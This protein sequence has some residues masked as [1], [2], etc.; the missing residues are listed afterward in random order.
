M[1]RPLRLA[2]TLATVLLLVLSS[3]APVAAAAD[4]YTKTPVSGSLGRY[5]ISA[6]HVAGVSS[7]G[8]LATQLQVAYSARIRGAAVFAAG[9]YYCAQNN[10]AQALYGCG[11]NRYPTNL[12]SLTSY[13]RTWASYGWVDGVGNLGGQPV[14]V[15][16]GGN[17]NTVKRS[18]TDDLVR[19]YQHFGASVQYDSG[20]A[21]GHAWVTPYGTVG[22]TATAAPFLN[23][24]GTDP[25]GAFLRK[26]LGSVAAPNT[27]P[28]GGTL[29]R[30]G[31]NTYAVNGWANG[32]SMDSSGFVYVPASCAAGQSCR[33][34]VALHGCLQGYGRVGT[35]FVD[36][37]NLNQYADTNRL[38]VLYP[39]ATTS[40]ANPNGCWDWWGY[41]GATNYPIKGGAQIETIMNMVR[42]LD[43]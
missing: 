7:G 43:G 12:P 33:L 1:R 15:F 4:P 14:Y 17:D 10:V 21:A 3:P 36:R 20:S 5:N 2:A 28:L 18:V 13:T 11:D 23:D 32:L 37:A 22:C 40:A 39:Q 31:Q 26:L 16:H 34:L 24:C 38:V 9:P 19:Y 25:Q 29:V 27:G 8:Y 41:L 42:R 35:A 6:V 30:F